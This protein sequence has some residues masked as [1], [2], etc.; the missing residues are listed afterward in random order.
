MRY[1]LRFNSKKGIGDFSKGN[2]L[3]PYYAVVPF[4]SRNGGE[5]ML[6]IVEL[7]D[8]KLLIEFT[9]ER[10]EFKQK[11]FGVFTK[12]EKSETVLEPKKNGLCIE[13]EF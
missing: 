11:F 9:I 10:E 5:K 6:R 2:C 7:C 4:L 8:G 3:A 13:I 1:T 12:V